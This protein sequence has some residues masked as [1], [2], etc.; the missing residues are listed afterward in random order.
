MADSTTNLGTAFRASKHVG[1]LR[2]RRRIDQRTSSK[3]DDFHGVLG[4]FS[5]VCPLNLRNK[6]DLALPHA[7]EHCPAHAFNASP[8]CRAKL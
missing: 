5:Q 6:R 2:H 8:F 3:F 7:T 1:H 4:W